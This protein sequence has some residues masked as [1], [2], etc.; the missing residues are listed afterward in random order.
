[1]HIDWA[2]LTAVAIVAAA[3]ALSVVLLVAFGIVALST[4]SDPDGGSTSGT[5]DTAREQAQ[6]LKESATEAGGQLLGEAKEEARAVGQ[7]ARRQLGDLW[8]QARGEVSDQA[9][10]FLIERTGYVEAVRP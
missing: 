2:S 7:E 4:R 5:A 10:E 9:A 3:A 1:M 8:S 6:H